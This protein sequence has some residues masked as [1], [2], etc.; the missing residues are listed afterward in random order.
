MIVLDIVFENEDLVVF[1]KPTGLPSAFLKKSQSQSVVDQALSTIPIL[2]NLGVQYE[3]GL[4]HR[5]DRETS[6]CLLFAKHVK[7]YNFLKARWKT[8]CV[9]KFYACLTTVDIDIA[10]PCRLENWMGHSKKSKKKMCI[11]KSESFIRSKIRSQPLWSKTIIHAKTHLKNELI[12]WEV[13][14]ETGWMHQIRGQ[15][16]YLGIPIL[17]DTLYGGALYH[18]L[19]LHA[20][21]IVIHGEDNPLIVSSEVPF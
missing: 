20:S 15:F 16:S 6:G 2:K 5:L 10:L 3:F 18:R 7:A 9:R 14:I 8:P 21:K 17:G 4:L 1:N 19:C 13:E 12:Q 11:S